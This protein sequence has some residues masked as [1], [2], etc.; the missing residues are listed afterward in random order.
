MNAVILNSH[1]LSDND[2]IVILTDITLNLTNK[3]VK[4][5]GHK[6]MQKYSLYK[7]ILQVVPVKQQ[8]EI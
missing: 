1:Q 6:Y 8:C 4:D 5:D 7:P 3:E 2:K